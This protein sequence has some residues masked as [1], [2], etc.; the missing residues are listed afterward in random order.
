MQHASSPIATP[1]QQCITLSS[2]KALLAARTFDKGGQ[3]GWIALPAHVEAGCC[4]SS[5][6]H[7]F[8]HRQAQ[9]FSTMVIRAGVSVPSRL[10][11]LRAVEKVRTLHGVAEVKRTWGVGYRALVAQLHGT[12]EAK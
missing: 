4:G 12:T 11:M 3:P 7:S 9:G 1:G 2:V 6:R 8:T 5:W 10:G